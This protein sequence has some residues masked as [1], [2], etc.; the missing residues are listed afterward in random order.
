MVADDVVLLCSGAVQGSKGTSLRRRMQR[1]TF[2]VH[3]MRQSD[4]VP[5]KP[6][7]PPAEFL[8]DAVF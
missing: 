4:E 1:L 8:S 3:A 7:V 6:V 5:G 2:C